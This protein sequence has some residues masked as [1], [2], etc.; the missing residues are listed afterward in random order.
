[1][2]EARTVMDRMTD[3]MLAHDFDT[4]ASLYAEQAVAATPDMGEIQGRERIVQYLQSFTDAFPDARYEPIRGHEAGNVAI[5]EGYFV[6]TNSGP[7]PGPSGETLPATGKSMRLRTCDIATIDQ[8]VITSHHFYYD[9]MEF[10]SQ[11]GLLPDEP[12]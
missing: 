7:L 2:G 1:M 8:G 5:D 6:G 12:V 10:L 4:V 3:A 9:Q 11:L